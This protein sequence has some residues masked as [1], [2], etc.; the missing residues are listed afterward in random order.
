M[1][2]KIL[3]PLKAR[4]LDPSTDV[5]AVINDLK[6]KGLKIISAVN[7]FKTI[8]RNDS[9]NETKSIKSVIKF[10]LFMLTFD[11]TK[12]ITR[13]MVLKL[14]HIKLLK[15]RLFAKIQIE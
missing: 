5:E 11:N 3:G 9:A 10:K 15:S 8:L 7:I 6:D 12:S 2:T 1:R 13:Y 14:L 4:D